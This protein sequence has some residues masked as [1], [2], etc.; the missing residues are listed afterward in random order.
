M[1][2]GPVVIVTRPV[3]Q[4][5]GLIA[6]LQAVG[7]ESRA[8]PLLH[9]EF[10]QAEDDAHEALAAVADADLWIFTRANAVQALGARPPAAWPAR[11]AAIG[12]ATAER[13]A[14]LGL[15]AWVPAEGSR[16]EDLL[17]DA[18]LTD[19]QDAYVVLIGGEGGR[20]MLAPALEARGARVTVLALYRRVPSTPDAEALAS[21]Q[22]DGT[23]IHFTS[24]AAMDQW[25]ALAGEAAF[26]PDWWVIS[27]RL[28]EHART[29]GYPRTPRVLAGPRDEDLVQALAAPSDDAMTMS[30]TPDTPRTDDAEQTPKRPEAP[31]PAVRRR[32]GLGWALLALLLLAVVL[33]GG[34]WSYHQLQLQQGAVGEL[35]TEVQR[36]T[37][38]AHE[39]REDHRDLTRNLRRANEQIAQF[40]ERLGRYDDTLGALNEQVSAGQERVQLAAVEHLLLIANDRLQLSGD[41]AAARTALQLADARL[42]RL[43][44]PRLFAVRE[45]VA[46]EQAALAAVPLPDRQGVALQL[47]GWIEQAA[48]LPLKARVPAEL[49]EAPAA[50][51]PSPMLAG[52]PWY[53]RVWGRIRAVA[54]QMFVLRKDPGQAARLLP[55][56][57]EALIHGMLRL[58][59]EN[60]RAAFLR[61]DDDS[62]QALLAGVRGWLAQYFALD[63]AAVSALDAGLRDLQ[64]VSLTVSPPDISG[65]LQR[66]RAHMEPAPR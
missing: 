63:H 57:E 23:L 12:A 2:A 1:S 33:A 41:V 59:L 39:L 52:A 32:S 58:Q 10:T 20:G 56:E 43:A 35:R 65:S 24:A 47:A 38:D 22:R 21:A 27:P 40:D 64:S 5:E 49:P 14:A 29:L 9:I 30:E 18:R 15:D 51:A 19:L 46:R 42:A 6:R 34:A 28:A 36:L 31:S 45:A 4:A 61:D 54:G 11:I 62:F 16:S 66:L 60:A 17:A 48:T 53:Q 26:A 25:K 44:D 13:L 50:E 37:A 3:A 55:S 7:V 8:L